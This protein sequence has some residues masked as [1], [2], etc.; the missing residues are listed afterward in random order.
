MGFSKPDLAHAGAS[1]IVKNNKCT[2]ILG[3]LSILHMN[4]G[5]WGTILG[6]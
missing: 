4:I 5:I 1:V 6:C 3:C 2:G